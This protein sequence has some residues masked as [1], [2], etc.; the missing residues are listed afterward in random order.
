MSALDLAARDSLAARPDVSRETLA[1]L[2]L[3]AALL[4]KWQQSIN[5]VGPETVSQLWQRHMLDSAQLWPLLPADTKRLV[6]LGSGGG[7]PGLVL[8][9]MGVPEVHLVESDTR[10]AIFLREAARQLAVRVTVYACRIDAAPPL[11]ADVVTA[12]ALAPVAKLIDWSRR[13]RTADTLLLLLKGRGAEEELA[14][15]GLAGDPRVQRHAS[16]TDA[17]ATILSLRGLET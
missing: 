10:K 15:A 17:D 16:L 11:A 6:D 9:A 14:A 4:V 12:R 8:A 13:F 1:K 7:F 3:Y 5:L 2:D